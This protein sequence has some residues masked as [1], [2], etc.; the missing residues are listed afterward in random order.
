[1]VSV[2]VGDDSGARARHLVQPALGGGQARPREPACCSPASAPS[3][4]FAVNEW[5]MASCRRARRRAS[6]RGR[7]SDRAGPGPSR[8]PRTCA[9]AADPRLGRAGGRAWRRTRSRGCRR[10]LRARRGLAGVG[11]AIRVGHF[12]DDAEE[13]RG[14]ACGG[15]ASKSSSSTRRCW[16][17]ASARH[18]TARPA[19]RFGKPGE[20]GRPLARV[21]ALR[22]DR[23]PAAGL[24]RDRRRPR[25][26][27]ADAAAADGRGRLG[28]DRGRRL[29]DAAGAG[30]R[31][32]G[33]ADGADRDPRRA[34]RDHA[35][36][37]AGRGGDPVRAADRRDP[38]RRAAARP[39]TSSPAASWA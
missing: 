35:R 24:R 20:L 14:G 17:P 4:G 23:R 1:M 34:A 21:A 19:P 13:A 36:P 6:E 8:P 27:R 29:L 9:G 26:R 16:R 15:S 2:K 37:A 3:K 33:G 39:S 18:R 31:L 7:S 22:A 5:E 11:D 10:E 28:Q 12:P 30:S 25:L 32:P 38:G